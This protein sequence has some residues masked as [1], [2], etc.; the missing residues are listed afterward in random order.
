LC[1]LLVSIAFQV[2]EDERGGVPGRESAEFFIEH[3]GEIEPTRVL[4]LGSRLGYELN[5]CP[6]AAPA[7]E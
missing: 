4:C 3:E 5:S 6:F 7:E 1:G 2:T